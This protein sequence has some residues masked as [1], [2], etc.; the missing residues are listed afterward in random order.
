MQFAT[1]NGVTL[2]YQLV[3]APEGKPVIVFSNSLGTDFRI[4]RDVIVQLVG[5]FAVI[6]YDKRG[7]G[8]SDVGQSPYT[9]DDHVDDLIGLL[10][11]LDIRGT[12]A[13]GL[14]VGGMIVQGMFHKRP[15][16][17]R[18]LVMCDTADRIGSEDMWNTRIADIQSQGLDAFADGILERWFSKAYCEAASP[19][20]YGYRNMLVRTPV[21]G[22]TGTCAA[23]RDADYTPLTEAISVPCVCVVGDEDAATTPDLVSGFAE[24]I[25]DGTFEEIKGAGHLPCIEQPL[26]MSEI[27]KAFAARIGAL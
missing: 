2:H 17:V 9:I 26:I 5:E 13:C 12:I 10:D 19:E 6:V 27:I 1:I 8:L 20:L 25:P 23:L 7:H 3:G 22:Y 15:D 11:H 14:S 21:E 4:W 16:L 18:G 24:G